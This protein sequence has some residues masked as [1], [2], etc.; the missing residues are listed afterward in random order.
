MDERIFDPYLNDFL[1]RGKE[2]TALVY[3]KLS[4][5]FLDW[6]ERRG[7][8][9]FDRGE[10][11]EFL[12]EQRR[13]ERRPW[14]AATCNLFLAFLRG[15]ARFSR[16]YAEDGREQARLSRLEGIRG[17]SV[18]RRERGALTLEQISDLL[19]IM[20]PD[21]KALLWLLLW[22][23]V[24]VGELGLIQS[25]DWERGRLVVETEK[26]GGTRPLYF[27]GYTG[28]VLRYAQERDLLD[29]PG[30]EV[31]RR[32]RRY[33]PYCSPVRLTPHVCRH[34]FATYFAPLVP[35]DV[36]RRM[37]GHGPRETT[38]LYVHPGEEEIRRAMQELHYLKP[39]EGED[40]GG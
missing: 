16:G 14:S 1:R 4:R 6:L 22:F 10:V 13:K 3:S 31:W 29:L 23:G 19:A 34:T 12:E 5:Q 35:R 7:L 18:Q 38:D 40:G 9:T 32:F 15:W 20:N 21:T 26:V 30:I 2:R 36:L 25:I 33:S 27:D 39:L 8:S 11:L 17:Y 28:R 37:L 24:R